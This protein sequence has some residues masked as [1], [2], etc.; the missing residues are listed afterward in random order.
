MPETTERD[1]PV[2][3]RPPPALREAFVDEAAEKGTNQQVLLCRILS[4]RYDIPYEPSPQSARRT[5]PRGG[6][7]RK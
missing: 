2:I 4:E 5:T 7:P 6:G 1:R 3:F